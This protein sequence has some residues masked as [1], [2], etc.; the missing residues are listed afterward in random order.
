MLDKGRYLSTEEIKSRITKYIERNQEVLASWAALLQGALVHP[1]QPMI[2]LESPDEEKEQKDDGKFEFITK[3]S[4]SLTSNQMFLLVSLSWYLPEEI[5]KLIRFIV[6]ENTTDQRVFNRPD[7]YICTE[8]EAVTL[9]WLTSNNLTADAYFG[10]LGQLLEVIRS[11]VKG[12][13]TCSNRIFSLPFWKPS[14]R[15]R[16][17]RYTGWRRHQNDH[18]A[19]RPEN[20]A[21]RNHQDDWEWQE[22]SR[23][24]KEE[25]SKSANDL[26]WFLYGAII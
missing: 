24:R 14:I 20:Y 10:G 1:Y 22:R 26:K 17:Q 6:E 16:V 3:F 21:S 12:S 7:I 18:G 11:E 4:G 8:N 15:K 9:M 23:R 5:Q 2:D 25:F 13:Q 19:M